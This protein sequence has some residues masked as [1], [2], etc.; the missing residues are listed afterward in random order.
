MRA[1]VQGGMGAEAEVLPLW[2]KCTPFAVVRGE[3]NAVPVSGVPTPTVSDQCSA[4][5]GHVQQYNAVTMLYLNESN[6]KTIGDKEMNTLIMP[7][8]TADASLY[9]TGGNYQ[10]GR[11]F[12]VVGASGGSG[13]IEAALMKLGAFECTGTCPVGQ[14]LCKSDTN[15]VC[16][17]NGCDTTPG[18]VAVCRST[19]GLGSVPGRN[20][21]TGGITSRT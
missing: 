18:G 7:G 10:T 2:A 11:R 8:F 1:E 12:N 20:F 19:P 3:I 13:T 6:L 14:L 21:S 16:C 15:C 4:V 9:K 17:K 5:P